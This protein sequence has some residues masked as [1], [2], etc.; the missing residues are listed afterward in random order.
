MTLVR[1]LVKFVPKFRSALRQNKCHVF[2]LAERDGPVFLTPFAHANVGQESLDDVRTH[3]DTH[4][5]SGTIF[6]TDK[7]G[8]YIDYCKTNPKKELM[9]CIIR[10]SEVDFYGFT[11]ILWLD[12]DDGSE[13]AELANLAADDESRLLVVTFQVSVKSAHNSTVF[14][15]QLQ[16][17]FFTSH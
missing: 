15:V 14:N 1:S 11:W 13:F 4:L 6:C 2:C 8:A 16:F 9:H 12:E 10:H 3:L 5:E 7:A 17:S